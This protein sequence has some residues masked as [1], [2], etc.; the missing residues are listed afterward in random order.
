MQKKFINIVI[1]LLWS[2]C[3]FSQDNHN[4]TTPYGQT[5]YYSDVTDANRTILSMDMLSEIPNDVTGLM[6]SF[7]MRQN[8]S[9]VVGPLKLLSFTQTTEQESFMDIFYENQTISIRRKIAPGS[10]YFYDYNLYDPMF[11][12]EN[13]VTTWEVHL[14]FL[15]CF[16][17]IETK[18]GH[19]LVNNV[20]HAPIF[21]GI[22]LPGYN[23]MS[24]YLGRNSNAK[25]VFGDPSP[26]ILFEMPNEIAVYGFNYLSLKNELQNNFCRDIEMIFANLK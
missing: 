11:E 7:S 21:F 18:K 23:F 22:D 1:F 15:G 2:L 16:M 5:L 3:I 9:E 17:W 25:I 20:W 4:Y 14:F 8:L 10:N 24:D 13:G 19:S 26:G 6:V 12:S